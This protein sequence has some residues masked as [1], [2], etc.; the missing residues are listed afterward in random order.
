MT[1]KGFGNEKKTNLAMKY[2][3]IRFYS[4]RP[5][6]TL[7]HVPIYIRLHGKRKVG[8]KRYEARSCG[9]SSPETLAF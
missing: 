6:N 8:G 2:N 3:L 9:R 5:K 7:D 1:E 4:G